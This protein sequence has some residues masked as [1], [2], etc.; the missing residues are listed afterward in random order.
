VGGRASGKLGC[1]TSVYAEKCEESLW[2]VFLYQAGPVNCPWDFF[3]H[4]GVR[5]LQ[6]ACGMVSDREFD[7]RGARG[8]DSDDYRSSVLCVGAVTDATLQ[9]D[10]NQAFERHVAEHS[11]LQG[12]CGLLRCLA[13]RARCCRIM[14]WAWA[15]T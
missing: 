7:S 1:S 5:P 6:M 8:S 4:G 3:G 10:A 2:G 15:P 12:E 9:H 13:I 14:Q 11:E